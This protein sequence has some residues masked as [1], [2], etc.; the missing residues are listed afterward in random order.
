MKHVLAHSKLESTNEPLLFPA[1]A[2]ELWPTCVDLCCAVDMCNIEQ[3][4]AAPLS[5]TP[6]P[7]GT[8][9]AGATRNQEQVALNGGALAGSADGDNGGA[10]IGAE[11]W[12]GGKERSVMDKYSRFRKAVAS[13]GLE[14]A[15]EMAPLA[16][17]SVVL[18]VFRCTDVLLLP[19]LNSPLSMRVHPLLYSL[20]AVIRRDALLAPSF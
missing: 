16:R 10:N 13:M 8:D 11:F 12:E 1:Q 2:K 14:R 19:P 3:P 4:K 6:P 17:V 18:V 5:T 7:T 9:A 15:W 20:L